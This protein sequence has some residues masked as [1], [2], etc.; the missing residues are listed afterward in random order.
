MSQIYP[1]ELKLRG[2]NHRLLNNFVNVA[3]CLYLVLFESEFSFSTKIVF[4]GISY[5]LLV[6]I[7]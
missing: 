4:F 7:N 1:V 6:K 5:Q 3:K 2:L